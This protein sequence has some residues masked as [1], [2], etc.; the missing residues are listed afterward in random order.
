MPLTGTENILGAAISSAIDAMSEADIQDKQKIWV[1]ISRVI[2]NHIV[3]NSD[4]VPGTLTAPSGG[5]PIVGIGK[6]V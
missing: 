6:I 2:I 1:D 5:G 3:A 4:L